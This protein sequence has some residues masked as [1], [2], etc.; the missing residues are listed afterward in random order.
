MR[1]D[2]ARSIVLHA[3]AREETTTGPPL[4]V[5]PRVVLLE[6]PQGGLVVLDDD[7]LLV[8]LAQDA[9]GLGVGI[10]ADGEVDSNHVVGRAGFQLG[11]LI[12]VDHV[13]RRGKDRLQAPCLVEVVMERAKRFDLG[14]LRRGYSTCAAGRAAG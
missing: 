7:A 11:A 12:G 3:H 5:G 10:V 1:A 2:A 14:H 8:P 6:R 9:G 13:V 4:A